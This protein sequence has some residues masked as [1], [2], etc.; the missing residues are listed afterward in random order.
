MESRP[1]LDKRNSIYA[2]PEALETVLR[3][4]AG[5]W[6]VNYLELEN[7]VCA[8]WHNFGSSAEG[9]CVGITTHNTRCTRYV[10]HPMGRCG[11]HFEAFKYEVHQYASGHISVT[12]AAELIEDILSGFAQ[13][14]HRRE[15][16]RSRVAEAL[17]LS[18][19]TSA[20]EALASMWADTEGA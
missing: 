1:H 13:D 18:D 3:R 6:Q 10:G 14:D 5:L 4:L 2:Q 9:Q 17:Q 16:L 11:Q 12:E 15:R 7:Q 19:E 8:G 20:R